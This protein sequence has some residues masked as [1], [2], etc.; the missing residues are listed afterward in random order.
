MEDDTAVKKRIKLKILIVI[1]LIFICLSMIYW[2]FVR[3]QPV[4]ITSIELLPEI[5]DA[6]DRSIEE[7]AQSV[8]DA[9]YFTLNISPVAYFDDGDSEGSIEIINPETNIYPI[10]VVITLDEDGEEIYQSGAI[11]PNQEVRRAKLNQVLGAGE[12]PT[13]ATIDIFDPDT[14][15]KIGSTQASLMFIINN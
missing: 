10:S 8:A 5:S 2:M 6:Q 11:Y 1:L 12:H 14:L 13:T 7:V 3:T 9:N 4:T 15:E